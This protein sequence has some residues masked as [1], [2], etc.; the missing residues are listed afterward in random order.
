MIL[1]TV[2]ELRQGGDTQEVREEGNRMQLAGKRIIV[3]G[4]AR[5]IAGSAVRAFA[6][7]G[8]Q[9]AS[10][11]VL[12]DL[13]EKVASEASQKGPG[14]VRFYHC[15][16]SNRAQVQSVFDAAVGHLGGLD[17]ML[18]IAAVER[19]GKAEELEDG[20]T[21]LILNV[22]IKGT[23]YTNQAAFKH[24]RDKGGSIVNFGSAAGMI[25]QPN[26][27][28]YAASKGAV[29]SWT[30]TVAKEWAKYG[31]R[32]NAMAPGIWTPMYEAHR[33]RMSPQELVSHD[34]MMAMVVSLGGKLGDP[35]RDMA[36]TLV[37][38]VS[39]GARF[40]TGQTIAVD[41]GLCPVR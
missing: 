14:K 24:L 32:V 30:R 25:G 10:L 29:L 17:A 5:G 3:T 41:G 22:N 35:D 11:D 20:D 34:K 4:G 15:D 19:T 16:I 12:D 27:A 38:M 33:A 7:E 2:V 36:P 37:F 23:I 13:G 8:A 39:D 18:N 40:I 9:V 28:H 31:I 26:A 1:L 6:V 21:E